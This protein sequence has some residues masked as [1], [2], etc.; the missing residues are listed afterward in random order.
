V[1]ERPILMSAPMVRAC[2]DGPKTQTRRIVKLPRGAQI[3]NDAP[4]WANFGDRP[5]WWPWIEDSEDGDGFL[6]CPYG[7]PGDR[8]W[9]R[10]TWAHVPTEEGM[11]YIYRADGESAFDCIREGWDFTGP[12]KPSIFCPRAASRITLEITGVRVERLLDITADDCRAEGHPQRAELSQEAQDDAARDWY[13]DLWISL[14]GKASCDAN[15]WVWV[16]EF[17]RLP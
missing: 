11:G 3:E 1:K 2:L 10:E 5:L 4:E 6:P 12:W 9:V 15:P 17:K 16:I 8:L 14:N 7:Q 13:M